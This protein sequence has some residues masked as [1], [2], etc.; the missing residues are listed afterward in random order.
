MDILAPDRS[1]DSGEDVGIDSK[2]LMAQQARAAFARSSI[3]Q[4]LGPEIALR[5]VVAHYFRTDDPD[6]FAASFTAFFY[7]N[8]R[9]EDRPS[10]EAGVSGECALNTRQ[11]EIESVA[12]QSIHW[13]LDDPQGG[14]FGAHEV[15]A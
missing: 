1:I 5:G 12:L 11:S 2:E 6:I 10:G 7:I 13:S 14:R 4:D 15:L 3:A 8:Q 9:V